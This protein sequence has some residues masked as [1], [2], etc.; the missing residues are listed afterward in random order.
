MPTN[1]EWKLL[2]DDTASVIMDLFIN[3]RINSGELD[4]LLNL[5]ETVMIKREHSELVELLKKWQPGANQS[6]IDDIIKATLLAI[7]FK[8]QLNIEHNVN[9]LRDL[10]DLDE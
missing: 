8:D 6:E 2:Y 5:L 3:G 1:S 4:F 7:D 9:I 10:I